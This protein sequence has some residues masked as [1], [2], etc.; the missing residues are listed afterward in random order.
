MGIEEDIGLRLSAQRAL[1][2]HIT[3]RM[4]AVSLD[5]DPGPHQIQVRIVFDGEPSEVEREVAACAGTEILSDYPE[6][7]D[8]REEYINCP[9]PGRMKHLRLLVYHRYEDEWVSVPRDTFKTC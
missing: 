6:G 1:L 4:R 2:T 7:W 9:A 3:P 8:I 5:I